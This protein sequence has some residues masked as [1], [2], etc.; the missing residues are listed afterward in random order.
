MTYVFDLDGT[1][2]DSSKR[3]YVLM[4]RLLVKEGIEIVSNFSKEFLGFKSDGHTGIEYLTNVLGLPKN[5]AKSIQDEWV[6]HIEDDSLLELDIL[7]QDALPV[8]SKINEEILFLTVRENKEGLETELGRL[9]L[10][11]YNTEI[12]RHGESKATVL[13][14]LDECIMIGDTEID[15]QA[16]IDKG[17]KSF[18][19]N[20][21]FRSKKYWDSKNVLSHSSLLK[22]IEK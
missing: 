4:K 6:D 8:L 14:R 16:S 19:L 1:L 17:C 11:K 5:K 10:S 12:I 22:L 7:Y 13:K 3:H 20:R 18:I 21:G 2:I 9:G 15:Y